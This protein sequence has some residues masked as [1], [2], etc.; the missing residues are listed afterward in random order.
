MATS[1]K[2]EI[3]CLGVYENEKKHSTGVEL[4]KKEQ[5]NLNVSC[6]LLGNNGHTCNNHRGYDEE[7]KTPFNYSP[8]PCFF[9][10]L[11][12]KSKR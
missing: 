5:G 2:V 12:S 7:T 6:Y 10:N 3:T 8:K 9:V 4:L 11:V 1:S